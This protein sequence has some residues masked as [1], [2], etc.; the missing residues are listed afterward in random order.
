MAIKICLGT[1]ILENSCTEY[2]PEYQELKSA[3]SLIKTLGV[4]NLAYNFTVK[5]K[6]TIVRLGWARPVWFVNI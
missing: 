5:C 2:S 3:A 1:W 6:I 4:R